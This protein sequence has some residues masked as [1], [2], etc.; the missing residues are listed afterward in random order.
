MAPTAPCRGQPANRLH[1]R[2]TAPLSEQSGCSNVA[3]LTAP[4]TTSH[5]SWVPVDVDA[6]ARAVS[7]VGQRYPA[8]KSVVVSELEEPSGPQRRIVRSTFVRE[9]LAFPTASAAA[10][11]CDP[12]R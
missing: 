11:N 4:S 2:G 9:F 8:L 12:S 10:S 1:R 6:L 7:A 5:G 3:R